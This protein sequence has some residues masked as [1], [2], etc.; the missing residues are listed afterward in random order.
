ME[1]VDRRSLARVSGLG[2]TTIH[3]I[4]EAP[5]DGVNRLEC[6]GRQGDAHCCLR[7]LN[8]VLCILMPLTEL[9]KRKSARE[10]KNF[11]KT[12]LGSSLSTLLNFPHVA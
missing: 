8:D 11:T 5:Q 2:C 12:Q 7:N 6:E 3:Y 9:A 10:G 1:S 4:P